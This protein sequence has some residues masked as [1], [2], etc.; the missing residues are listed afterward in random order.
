MLIAFFCDIKQ[1]KSELCEC[2]VERYIGIKFPHQLVLA[3]WIAISS[4]T[5]PVSVL[6]HFAYLFMNLPV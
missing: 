5:V 6:F 3:D 1:G 4:K 2:F